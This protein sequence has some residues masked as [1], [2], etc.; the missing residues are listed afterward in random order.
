MKKLI[1]ACL[2]ITLLLS[3]TAQKKTETKPAPDLKTKI[4]IKAGPNMSTARVYQNDVKQKAIMC[5]GME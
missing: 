1:F 4:A 3:A 5:P 2:S